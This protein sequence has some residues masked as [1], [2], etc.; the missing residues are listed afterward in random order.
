MSSTEWSAL[1]NTME[2]TFE[3]KTYDEVVLFANKVMQIAI[4]QD[5]HPEI[6]IQ[7]NCVKVSI[8]DYEYGAV[9]EKCHRFIRA[10]NNC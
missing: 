9:S 4:H 8:T 3:F 2:K 6:N 1:N 7:Y 10:V 5:H